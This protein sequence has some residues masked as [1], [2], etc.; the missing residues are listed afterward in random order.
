MC[1]CVCVCV[2]C[3]CVTCVCVC[4]MG[5]CNMGVCVACVCVACVCVSTCNFY[6]YYFFIN[7]QFIPNFNKI[8]PIASILLCT[9]SLQDL[10]SFNNF[11]YNIPIIS[12]TFFCLIT[13]IN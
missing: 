1:V 5:V 7:S 13:I 3:V 11:S 4:N 8:F 9:N 2:V 6:F 12:Y 10:Y